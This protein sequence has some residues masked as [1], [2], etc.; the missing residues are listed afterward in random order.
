MDTKK[1]LD[2]EGLKHLWSKVNSRI[3][4]TAGFEILNLTVTDPMG[5]GLDDCYRDCWRG[6]NRISVR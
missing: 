5:G 1:Y 3:D 6:S 4:E 2:Y